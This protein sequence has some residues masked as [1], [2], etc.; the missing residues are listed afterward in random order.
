MTDIKTAMLK[1]HKF[2]EVHKLDL[3]RALFDTLND[4]MLNS[5]N[6]SLNHFLSYAVNLEQFS[7]IQQRKTL[8]VCA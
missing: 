3:Y 8:D 6:V 4:V 7:Y 5:P 1:F 2:H